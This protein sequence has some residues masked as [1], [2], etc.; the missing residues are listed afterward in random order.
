MVSI[1][2]ANYL[3]FFNKLI[4]CCSSSTTIIIIIPFSLLLVFFPSGGYPGSW[5]FEQRIRQNALR[6]QGQNEVT[7][8][9]I[10]RK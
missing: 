9:E 1:Y 10:Y 3:F 7:K 2:P 4:C 5:D 8:A 6:E